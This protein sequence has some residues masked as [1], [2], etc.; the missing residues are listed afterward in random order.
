[1]GALIGPPNPA[2]KD[3]TAGMG[4]TMIPDADL[5]DSR[6][7]FLKAWN[8][9][10]QKQAWVHELPGDWPGGVLA[11]AGDLV[12]QGRID[13]QFMAYDA[14]DGK[15]VWSYKTEAPVVAT[16]ISYRANGKQYVTVLTGSG[17][18]GGGILATG[19]AAYR[20]DYRLPR[21][22]LTFAINGKDTLPPFQ[23]PPL[24][25]PADPDFT[26]DVERVTQG[27]MVF[28]GASCLVCHG[29]NAI[30]GGAAPDLRYSPMI[31]SKEAFK[32]VVKEG[33]LKGNGMPAFAQLPDESLEIIRYYLRARAKQTAADSTA[34]KPASSAV[35]AM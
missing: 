14:K 13:S 16:P 2:V 5:P 3:Y 27:A 23:L 26:L 10:T 9:V 7:S 25:A 31:V 33:A 24:V 29:M 15:Q 32:A 11:T 1:L 4:V 34:T 35:P 30:G 21:H 12:F 19:N 22:V 8:P 6:K 28:A 20:T 17:S 18:Q